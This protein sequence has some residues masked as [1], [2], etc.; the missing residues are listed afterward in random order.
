[1]RGKEEESAFEMRQNIFPFVRPIGAES[2]AVTGPIG[3]TG[4]EDG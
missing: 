3:P 1:M 4:N 2:S